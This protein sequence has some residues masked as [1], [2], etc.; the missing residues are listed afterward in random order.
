MLLHLVL[1]CISCLPHLNFLDLLWEM[2]ILWSLGRYWV[3]SRNI[4]RLTV[5]WIWYSIMT[6]G[7]TLTASTL[8]FTI[9]TCCSSLLPLSNS[10]LLGIVP[11]KEILSWNVC[12][13]VFKVYHISWL[14]NKRNLIWTLSLWIN[15]SLNYGVVLTL[16][17]LW[18]FARFSFASIVLL[19]VVLIL[20]E[21]CLR[22][23][24]LTIRI[25]L[26]TVLL[27]WT[28]CV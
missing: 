13:R 20:I 27:S 7:N 11:F 23:N 3:I 15:L 25:L 14:L 28:P 16:S 1:R 2:P 26:W 10:N 5:I 19:K 18:S 6:I 8:T 21:T 12:C 9:P 22:S 17:H 4:W 24:S